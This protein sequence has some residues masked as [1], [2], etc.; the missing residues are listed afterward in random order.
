MLDRCRIRWGYVE[1][2]TG[3]LVTVRNRLLRFDGSRLVLGPEEVEVARG[4]L[5]GV[6]LAPPMTVGDTVSL[7]WDWVCDRLTPVG[8]ANLASCTAANLAAVN[9]LPTPGPAA[10]CGAYPPARLGADDFTDAQR[11]IEP[12]EALAIKPVCLLGPEPAPD[13]PS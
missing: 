9:A 6:G 8:L 1:S 2:V 10:A 5:H 11:A 12:I 4:S 3:D 7:H 13:P